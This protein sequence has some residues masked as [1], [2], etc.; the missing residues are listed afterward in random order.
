MSKKGFQDEV[1]SLPVLF[2]E[3]QEIVEAPSWLD[4][5][6]FKDY[7]LEVLPGKLLPE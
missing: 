7:V 6:T 5:E 4:V 2:E 1:V 3:S